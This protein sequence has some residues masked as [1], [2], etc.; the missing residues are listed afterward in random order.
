M[1]NNRSKTGRKQNLI[2]IIL[3]RFNKLKCKKDNITVFFMRKLK[4]YL[5]NA[6]KGSYPKINRKAFKILDC[7]K[8]MYWRS[9]IELYRQNQILVT[10]AIETLCEPKSEKA[11]QS[12]KNSSIPKSFNKNFCKEFFTEKVYRDAFRLVLDLIFSTENCEELCEAFKFRCC[13]SG[14]NIHSNEC[15]E[16]WRNLKSF[17]GYLLFDELGIEL[18]YIEKDKINDLKNYYYGDETDVIS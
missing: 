17:F 12:Q 18:D 10:K 9:F 13:E 4:F 1:E 15:N 14:K 5:K 11:N 3:K 2:T 7:S 16:K 6:V 8:D